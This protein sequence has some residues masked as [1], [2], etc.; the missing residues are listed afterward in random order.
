MSVIFGPRLDFNNCPWDNLN[1]DCILTH[2]RLFESDSNNGPS[3]GF[4]NLG[5][6]KATS[7]QVSHLWSPGGCNTG[8]VPEA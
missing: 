8:Q 4:C 3:P 2:W 6:M 5:Q 7:V 1:N